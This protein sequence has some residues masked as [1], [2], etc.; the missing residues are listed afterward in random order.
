MRAAFPYAT[1]LA[2]LR[3]YS[4]GEHS[5]R[6]IGKMHKVSPATLMGWA[7]RAQIKNGS[8][9]TEE[10]L[11]EKIG[12]WAEE[13][14]ALAPHD[15]DNPKSHKIKERKDRAKFGTPEEEKHK[16][17]SQFEKLTDP[18]DWRKAIDTHFK[19]TVAQLKNE[20]LTPEG[21]VNM[22]TLQMLLV[23]LKGMVDSPPP[24]LT[25]SDAERVIKLTRLTLGMDKDN[26][27]SSR[28]ADLRI[29]NAV[30]EK[31]KRPKKKGKVVE[32]EVDSGD[33]DESEDHSEYEDG[34]Q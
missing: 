17:I 4:A 3:L 25:W 29:L 24:V 7:R 21:Q 26:G 32:A 28:G 8:K 5:V 6:E 33:S 13:L 2:C 11:N 23:Q 31:E 15:P 22:L 30:V 19:G 27:D 14:R 12:H 9:L 18:D 1:R 20:D 16:N 34:D 10:E